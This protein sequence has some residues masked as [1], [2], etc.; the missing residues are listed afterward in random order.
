V[1]ADCHTDRG[2]EPDRSRDATPYGYTDIYAFTYGSGGYSNTDNG[3]TA[4]SHTYG[5]TYGDA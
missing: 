5:Y 1:D 4:Y 2:S 3:G